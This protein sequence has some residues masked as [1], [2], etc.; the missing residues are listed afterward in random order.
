MSG[1]YLFPHIKEE[2]K[3][4]SFPRPF[5]GVKIRHALLKEDAGVIG[6]AGL[7]LS[8]IQNN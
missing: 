7:A 8:E 3:K 4:R 5:K 1:K 6:A 2:A